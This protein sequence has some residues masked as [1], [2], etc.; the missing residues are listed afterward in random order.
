MP[1]PSHPRA[2]TRR[3]RRPSFTT[4]RKLLTQL[5]DG[6]FDWTYVPVL[7]EP[8]GTE[9]PVDELDGATHERSRRLLCPKK[10]RRK[11]RKSAPANVVGMVK[12]TPAEVSR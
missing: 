10:R 2:C 12:L 1:R 11:P 5:P 7:V 3:N 9:T 8:D 4:L 6:T